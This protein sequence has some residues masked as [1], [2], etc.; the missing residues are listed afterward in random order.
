MKVPLLDLT[1]QNKPLRAQI[2]KAITRVLDSQHFI[3]GPDVEKLE[4][5]VA[6][7]TRTPFAIGVS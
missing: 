5:A 6:A 7:Y 1:P 2:L 4:K 3:M